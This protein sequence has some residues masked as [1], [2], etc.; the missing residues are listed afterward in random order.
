[1]VSTSI[2]WN[3]NRTWTKANYIMP[4][5]Y[6]RRLNLTEDEVRNTMRNTGSNAHAARYLRIAPTTWKKYARMYIDSETGLTLYDLHKNQG[7]Q[8]LARKSKG[9]NMTPLKSILA[10]EH[11]KYPHK[12][13]KRR[14]IMEGVKA[15]E[16]EYCGFCERRTTDYTVPLI[17]TFKDGNRKNH[18]LDNLELICYNCYY[19]VHGSLFNKLGKN[20]V[21]ADNT[22][23]EGY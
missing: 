22:N 8:G 15:E 14:I 10:G 21:N 5:I 9:G 23:F 1:M 3:I 11:P 4:L 6:H 19:L 12:K 18:L 17:L 16:C 7:G 2:R 13:I 20:R